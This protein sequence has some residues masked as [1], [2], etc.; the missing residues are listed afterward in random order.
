MPT[1][2]NGCTLER[3][4]ATSVAGLA[5]ARTV[6]AMI[7]A[8]VSEALDGALSPLVAGATIALTV[9]LVLYTL[10]GQIMG[11]YLPGLEVAP[12]GRSA[13]WERLRGPL[14]SAVGAIALVV[15]G[16]LLNPLFGRIFG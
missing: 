14:L 7:G 4:D 3:G 8:Y 11:R 5:H 10:S 16:A 1:V 6:I 12:E 9:V 15:L 13:R 2:A